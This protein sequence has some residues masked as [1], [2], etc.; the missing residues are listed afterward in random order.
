M[1][2]GQGLGR[3]L[4]LTK[5]GFPVSVEGANSAQLSAGRNVAV[6][7]DLKIIQQNRSNGTP[8]IIACR[9]RLR[10]HLL[11]GRGLEEMWL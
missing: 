4:T 6:V 8:L 1:T 5:T 7:I 2:P 9:W 3:I 11:I 10:S